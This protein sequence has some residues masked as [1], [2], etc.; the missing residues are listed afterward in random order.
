MG[1]Y[2]RPEK[3]TQNLYAGIDKAVEN[4]SSFLLFAREM[5][6]LTE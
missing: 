6:S 2:P 4:I 5:T 3:K 1:V